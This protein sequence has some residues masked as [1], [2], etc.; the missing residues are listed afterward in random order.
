MN[1]IKKEVINK[2]NGWSISHKYSNILLNN[3]NKITLEKTLIIYGSFLSELKTH[4]L[5][6]T[7]KKYL[8]CWETMINTYK[9]ILKKQFTDISKINFCIKQLHYNTTLHYN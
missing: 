2:Q 5:Y 7:N 8:T 9:N 4:G 6:I 1:N 3:L